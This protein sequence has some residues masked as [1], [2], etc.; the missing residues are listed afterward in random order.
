MWC[1]GWVLFCYSDPTSLP[2]QLQY[3]SWYDHHWQFWC[4]FA[5]PRYISIVL[6]F[7][8]LLLLL[9]QIKRYWYKEGVGKNIRFGHIR[10]RI[11]MFDQTLIY[12]VNSLHSPN[13]SSSPGWWGGT[14][15]KHPY[16][17]IMAPL[18]ISW[19][20][21]QA[22]STK[23]HWCHFFWMLANACEC[24]LIHVCGAEKLNLMKKQFGK[25]NLILYF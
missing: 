24:L 25:L 13:F 23:R 5:A 12:S 10:V 20:L 4:I 16:L 8:L 3:Q 1:C 15:G 14:Y 7:L 18:Y 6:L 22:F 11:Q 19:D 17:H 2:V 21:G 9:Y